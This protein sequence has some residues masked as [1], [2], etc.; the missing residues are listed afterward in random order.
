MSTQKSLIEYQRKSA[1]GHTEVAAAAYS[2]AVHS[3]LK[4][5]TTIRE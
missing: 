4:I 5:N 3:S 2:L 1:M